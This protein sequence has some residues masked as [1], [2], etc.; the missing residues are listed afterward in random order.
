MNKIKYYFVFF[1]FNI[2]TGT[3]LYSQ[4]HFGVQK[5][6]NPVL[7]ANPEE[8][9]SSDI[10]GD[11]D[12]D[13]VVVSYW[14]YNISWFENLDG[15]VNFGEQ[16]FITTNSQRAQV[17]VCADLDGDGD[18]DVISGARQT[19]KI[20]WWENLDGKG[21]FSDEKVISNDYPV[22]DLFVGDFDNDND[23]DVMIAF[24]SAIYWYE[25]KGD[26]G[27]DHPHKATEYEINGI[28]A[29]YCADM[30]NDNDLDILFC[31]GDMDY[32]GWIKNVDGMGTFGNPLQ[33][34]DEADYPVDISAVDMDGDG[35]R[36][37]LVASLNDDRV[38]WF[39]NKD[40]KGTF[41]LRTTF[42]GTNNNPSSITGGDIDG[43]G[44]NDILVACEY[45]IVGY[46]NED[47]E[48]NI[49]E[50]P[51]YISTTVMG[52]KSAKLNDLDGD[53]DL[54]VIAAVTQSARVVWY[55]NKDGQ[56]DFSEQ[57]IIGA[58][59]GIYP[60][61]IHV[62]DLDGDGDNDILAAFADDNQVL[63][64]E[65]KDGLGYF[66]IPKQVLDNEDFVFSIFTDDLD[67]DGDKDV[68]SSALF[69]QS[70]V[71]VENLDG[72]GNFGEKHIISDKIRFR[73]LVRT[74]DFDS[75]GD[76][77]VLFSDKLHGRLS[78]AENLDGHANF[79]ASQQISS[80]PD[81]ISYFKVVDLD[82]DNDEDILLLSGSNK[83]IQW[84]ENMS[85]T[86]KFSDMSL[87][88]SSENKILDICCADYDGDF[89]IDIIFSSEN[90]LIL[91]QNS[92]NLFTKHSVIIDNIEAINSIKNA[93]FDL[94]GD[95]DI[96]ICSQKQDA[97][98]WLENTN[99]IALFSEPVLISD[100]T[101]RPV[102]VETA[103]L[104]GDGYPD[105]ISA[106]EWDDKIAWYQNKQLL[107]IL[108]NPI[109]KKVCEFESISFTIKV[110]QNANFQWQ[111]KSNNS[112]IYKDIEAEENI[113][114][115]NSDSL[116]IDSVSY[117]ILNNSKFR[118][119]VYYQGD[120]LYSDAARLQII[121]KI[122]ADAGV[123]QYIC[124]GELVQLNGYPSWPAT[125]LWI[126]ENTNVTFSDSTVPN[127][128][129]YGLL[130]GK[131]MFV[132]TL[133]HDLCP[134]DTDSTFITLYANPVI[135]S[136]PKSKDLIEGE[137]AQFSVEAE[138]DIFTYQWYKDDSIMVNNY[139]INGVDMP[140]LTILNV[141]ST[142]QGQ[143][144][145]KVI[146]RCDTIFSESA[147]LSTRTDLTEINIKN[148]FIVYPNPVVAGETLFIEI[149]S[150]EALQISI[151]NVFGQVIESFDQIPKS[152][153][154]IKWST[155]NCNSGIY[156]ILIE[157]NGTKQIKK[158]NILK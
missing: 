106:S 86:G 6:L 29:I 27:F 44:N 74:I 81:F 14:D 20:M 117:D 40:G 22:D 93:D 83:D 76:R 71:W 57:K 120:S 141:D 21:N 128:L 47:G 38:R 124:E 102:D 125:G 132:W 138:G 48:G 90:S 87:L 78:W 145:C 26:Q 50:N 91:L 35:S 63:W 109:D 147:Y 157:Q 1:I 55:D 146:G 9:V 133:T 127:S 155:M 49:F 45:M 114:G 56:G 85:G 75:D 96:V 158:I 4:T 34:Y 101:I 136:Q 139:K 10:D 143:Y 68:L 77:D 105:V 51:L 7:L 46:L 82:S 39:K 43:D 12:N 64:F 69:D 58:S 52:A 15:K 3:I 28:R 130:P 149:N 17:V 61:D 121:P 11:G 24:G 80:V 5:V 36:D 154:I 89:D 98:Y 104:T 62:D 115:I 67:G 60:L 41:E 23:N 8:V 30:D 135:I 73:S 33:I 92:N 72:M 2:F 95:M 70:L 131:T 103:D 18:Q 53:G 111:R 25:N 142:D 42:W 123:D 151:I 97:I 108:Y 134:G 107:N 113:S 100:K 153:N 126:C 37:L 119:K 65:N 110:D 16:Q 150:S 31:S 137:T 32:V 152:N 129:V 88:Y 99:G 84:L 144:K 94:D 19:T 116:V 13:I 112:S 140:V 79:A 59:K 156:F 66:D 54:D 122:I 148:N 118:C